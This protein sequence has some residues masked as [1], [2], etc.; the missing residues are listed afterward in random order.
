MNKVNKV[1]KVNRVMIVVLD[2]C[3]VGEMPDAADYGDAGSNT[4][5]N[6][7][8]A[9]GGL[10]LPCL[11][12]LGL[13]N[14]ISIP[15]V[16]PVD[17][18]RACY[19]KMAELSAGKD[20]T[21]GHWEIMGLVTER[22]FPVY[23]AGFPD[24]IIITFE[25]AIG[26]KILGNKPA[27]G[28]EIIAE[29]GE[30]HLKTGNP[31]VYTSQDSVFQ[32]AAHED[33]IDPDELYGMCRTA[34]KIL[35]GPDAVA[36]VIARPFVG[37]PGAFKRTAG[38]KDFSLPPHGK[39]VLDFASEEGITTYAVGK[40]A[41]IFDWQGIDVAVKTTGNMD[42]IDA[43]IGL[44]ER[45]ERALII[46]TLTDFDMLWGH[47]NDVEGFKSGL[48]AVDTR[49]PELIRNMR[50]DDVLILTADHGCDPTTSSTDHSREYVPLLILGDMIRT[51]VDLGIRDSFSDIAKTVS[52][53]MDLDAEVN[54]ASL[55]VKK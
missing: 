36:R 4:F 55:D 45:S 52:D 31:I 42:T 50:T 34:R 13:G 43:V 25:K 30:E 5:L 12:A 27:S 9:T 16:P 53:L 26:R 44:M 17:D 22:P 38:R 32:I 18:P 6:T 11:Q 46:S 8:A 40:T 33:M 7:A 35:T 41:E 15:G 10:K 1:N 14:V 54:G 20:T 48:E 28:T 19:G 3:G 2:G 21:V 37:S 51:G 23:P 24:T 49:L 29:L 47:R 39:T